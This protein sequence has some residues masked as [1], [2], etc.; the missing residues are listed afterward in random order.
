[1]GIP[2]NENFLSLWSTQNCSSTTNGLTQ[3]LEKLSRRTIRLR[4]RK[5]VMSL[6]ETRLTSTWPLQ[7]RKKLS[8]INQSTE[9]WMLQK[10]A[11]FC[12]NWLI[13]LSK[14]RF[15]KEIYFLFYC[16]QWRISFRNSKFITSFFINYWKFLKI[17]FAW[18]EIFLRRMPLNYSKL[19]IC[20][21]YIRLL[22]LK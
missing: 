14:I 11:N 17:Y 1:M 22:D 20:L 6:K 3:N 10:E 19:F 16:D 12:G 13:S 9:I 18:V 15:L 8:L 21:L 7:L 2:I 5:F 4:E